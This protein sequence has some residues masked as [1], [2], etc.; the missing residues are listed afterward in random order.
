M[1]SIFTGLKKAP[2]GLFKTTG[3]LHCLYRH[4]LDFG[5]SSPLPFRSWPPSLACSLA[6]WEAGGQRQGDLKGQSGAE[7]AALRGCTSLPCRGLWWSPLLPAQWPWL[8]RAPLSG[9][10]G[11]PFSLQSPASSHFPA[12]LTCFLRDP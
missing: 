2:L 6:R 5:S 4:P 9:L 12:P 1:L 11:G 7:R 8:F 3:N 10:Q